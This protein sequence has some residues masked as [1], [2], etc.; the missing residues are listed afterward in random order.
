MKRLHV[1]VSVPDLQGS[2]NFYNTLFGTEPTVAK[3]D[4][5][6]WMLD[7]PAVNFAISVGHGK[8]G[9]NHLGLQFD[10]DEAVND[11]Q[12]R[13]EKAHISGME[14]KNADCCYANSNKYWTVD[15]A[16]IPWEQFHT[17]ADIPSFGDR[18]ANTLNA[19]ACGCA[20]AAH[21]KNRIAGCCS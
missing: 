10:S 7:D 8:K 1:H 2:I 20:P 13:L 18:P 21:V 15:P 9:I 11:I 5:A 19:A 4:Y 3:D 6:K 14:Q 17:L 12:G 16:G